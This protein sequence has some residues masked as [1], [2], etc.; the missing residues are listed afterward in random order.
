MAR[1]LTTTRSRSASSSSRSFR[2]ACR[3]RTVWGYGPRVAQGLIF[4]APSLTIEAKHGTPVRVKWVNERE[5]PADPTSAYL[6]TSSRRSNTALGESAWWDG[7]P[8]HAAEFTSTPGSYTGPVPIVTHVHGSAG[9]GDESDGYAEAWFLP[10]AGDIP[11]GYATEGTWYDF[12]QG[13][14]ASRGYVAPDVEWDPGTAVFQYPPARVNDLVPRPHAGDDPA[15]RVRRTGR[16]LPHPRRAWRRGV[17]QPDRAPA[18]LPGPA[19][20]IGDPPV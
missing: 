13:K 20:A 3:Q 12:F 10:Q 11:S 1:T 6:P 16:L 5:D 8:R 18:V 4:N 2:L 19:P 9:V 14:A 17:R 7:R 15:Q